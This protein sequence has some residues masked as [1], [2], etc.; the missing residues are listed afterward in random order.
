[1]DEPEPDTVRAAA[2]GDLNAFEELVRAYQVHVWRFL[3]HLLG[4]AD[5]AED[6]TQE[7]F[8]RVYRRLDSFRFQ[9]KFSTWMF[10]V[11][12]NIAVDSVRSQARQRRLVD[13]LEAPTSTPD[14]A[15][16]VEVVTAIASLTPK[17]REAFV[18]VEAHGLTYREAGQVLGVPEGTVKSRVFHARERLVRWFSAGESGAEASGEVCRCPAAA[19]GRDRRGAAR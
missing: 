18:L 17:L 1:M 2:A 6:L 15:T 7:T 8:I 5:L 13:A 3:K 4:D 12:R 19:V 16:R 10:Q 9:S 11:A 14:G